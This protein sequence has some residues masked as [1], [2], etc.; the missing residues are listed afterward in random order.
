M[1]D[2]AP[3]RP[4]KDPGQ[5]GYEGYARQSGGVSWVTGGQLPEWADLPEKIRDG[6][7]AAAVAVITDLT[8]RMVAAQQGRAGPGGHGGRP[9]MEPIMA[10]TKA[11]PEGGAERDSEGGIVPQER[12]V[13]PEDHGT[14]P[15]SDEEAARAREP[16]TGIL[17]ARDDDP[18]AA[19]PGPADE[20]D[21]EPK[22]A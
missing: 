22:R 1:T 10:D 18:I 5:I 12:E 8:G 3:E 4:D 9:G 13:P 14:E 19:T 11:N 20:N 17:P 21:G 6:W 15:V 2:P 7:R 16:R